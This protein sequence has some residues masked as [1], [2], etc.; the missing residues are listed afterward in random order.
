VVWNSSHGVLIPLNN[1]QVLEFVSIPEHYYKIGHQTTSAEELR[2]LVAHAHHLIRVK[3]AEHPSS[4]DDVLKKLAADEHPE[5][6]I[7]VAEHPK[8][9]ANVLEQLIMDASVDVRYALAEN[10]SLP[11]D[12][13]QKL[14]EDENVYV[15]S[16]AMKTLAK[17]DGIK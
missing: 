14:S 3:I 4:P 16:R 2:D 1:L 10:H 5:V 8:T 11:P 9:P 12:L 6:R 17:L 13:L 7:A 15:S